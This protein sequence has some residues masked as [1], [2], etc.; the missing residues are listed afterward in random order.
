MQ[1]TKRH[2]KVTRLPVSLCCRPR[3]RH[4]A[5]VRARLTICFLCCS[6]QVKEYVTPEKF[7]HWREVGDKMGFLYTASGEREGGVGSPS[8]TPL[9]GACFFL[10]ADRLYFCACRS[11]GRWCAPLTRPA[12]SSCL[13][14]SRSGAPSRKRPPSPR[15]TPCLPSEAIR[16]VNFT[17]VVR[18]T[19]HKVSLRGDGHAAGA[20]SQPPRVGLLVGECHLNAVELVVEHNLTAKARAVGRGGDTPG[21]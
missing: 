17:N 7:D 5:R 3:A 9:T 10:H 20:T 21:T 12:S 1:P 15:F 16:R 2:L 8:P 11:Q 6:H 4:T 19:K 14:S 18:S 13:I